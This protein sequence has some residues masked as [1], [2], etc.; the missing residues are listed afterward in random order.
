M[1]SHKLSDE[2]FLSQ[3]RPSFRFCRGSSLFSP[4]AP[5]SEWECAAAGGEGADL[6]WFLELYLGS[7][8]SIPVIIL[9]FLCFQSRYIRQ[10]M[11]ACCSR[12]RGSGSTRVPSI[13]IP[14]IIPRFLYF[15]S[16]WI[17]RWMRA[18]SG[19][20]TGSGSTKVPLIQSLLNQDSF[21]FSPGAPGREWDCAV[22]GGEG[23][24]LRGLVLIQSP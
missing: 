11:R 7:S 5:G 8:N 14:V 4:G 13:L 23:M 17:R 9:W 2:I 21:I 6:P 12:H 10:W 18:C 15:Q 19:R 1:F 3:Q 20:H 22:A 16:R 24:D